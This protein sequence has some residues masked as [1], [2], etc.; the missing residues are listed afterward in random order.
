MIMEKGYY[1]NIYHQKTKGKFEKQ[2]S[3]QVNK[4]NAMKKLQN[5]RKQG[6]HIHI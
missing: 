3:Y 4:S 6:A 1:K 5:L 2:S